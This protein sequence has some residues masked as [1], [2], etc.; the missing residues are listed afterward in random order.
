MNELPEN[1][2]TFGEGDNAAV[3]RAATSGESFQREDGRRSRVVLARYAHGGSGPFAHMGARFLLAIV[4]VGDGRFYQFNGGV[5]ERPT[6]E[7]PELMKAA[8]DAAFEALDRELR[9]QG[10]RRNALDAFA[11]G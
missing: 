9:V 5:V 10:E 8:S 4:E 1:Q 7:L 11:D 6:R 2:G 3:W